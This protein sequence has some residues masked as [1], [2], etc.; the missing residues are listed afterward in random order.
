DAA[1]GAA[2]QAVGELVPL[3][4]AGGRLVDRR[5]GAAIV[6]HP[7]VAPALIRRRVEDVWVAAVHDEIGRP[8]LVIDVQN[9]LPGLA[10]IGRLEDAAL[11]VGREQVAQRR[12]V[13]DVRVDRVDDDASDVLAVL[14]AHV[15]PGAAGVGRFVNAV[16]PVGA[17]GT[18]SV[19]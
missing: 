2:R 12:D 8:G 7:A 14:Q 5:A 13:D 15:L 17:A 3:G 6:Q 9:L 4:T 16:A 11:F 18:G 19:A 10:A 1:D